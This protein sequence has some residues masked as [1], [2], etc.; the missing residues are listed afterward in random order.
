MFSSSFFFKSFLLIFVCLQTS[1]HTLIVRY[2][3]FVLHENYLISSTI[4]VGELLKLLFSSLIV[5]RSLGSADDK[6][7]H[8]SLIFRQSLPMSVPALLYYCQGILTFVGLQNLESSIYAVIAQ[9]KLLTTAFISVIVMK[10]KLNSNQWRALILLVIGVILVQIRPEPCRELNQSETIVDSDSDTHNHGNSSIGLLAVLS[11]I[12]LSGISGVYLEF[13][14]K[15]TLEFTIWERNIQLSF[16]G[17]FFGILKILF[18]SSD[19][20]FIVQNSFFHGYSHFTWLIIGLY[21]AGGLAVAGVIAY[22]DNII[23][24]FAT[25]C[26]LILTSLI[27]YFWFND[28]KIDGSFICGISAVIIAIFNYSDERENSIKNNPTLVNT[29]GIKKNEEIINEGDEENES[30]SLL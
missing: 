12:T 24:G 5:F 17:I 6:F 22:F 19:Y 1:G 23:K 3:Q 9:G 7:S 14:L 11:V 4:I 2:S 18:F 30:K 20:S 29:K 28:L 21:S 15:G 27:S 25:S 10:K 16:Y 26:S 13:H 8:F